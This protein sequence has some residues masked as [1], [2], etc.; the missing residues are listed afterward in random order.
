MSSIVET[1][2]LS[3]RPTN[4]LFSLRDIECD[5]GVGADEAIEEAFDRVTAS[6]GYEIFVAAAQS[7][8]P[9]RVSLELWDG[10]PDINPDGDGW[11]RMNSSALQCP[12]G[13]LTLGRDVSAIDGEWLPEPGIYNVVVYFK[14]RQEAA[15][16]AVDIAQDTLDMNVRETVEYQRLHG[17]DIEQYVIRMWWSSDLPSDDDDDSDD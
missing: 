1:H 5:A 15:A 8:L 9:I 11:T 13:H 12:S 6:T 14:G 17:A 10:E 3:L 16:R 7:D 4:S 2:S